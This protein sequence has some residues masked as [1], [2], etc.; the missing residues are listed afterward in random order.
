MKVACIGWGSLVW[1]PGEIRCAGPWQ[2]DGPLLPLEFARTSRDGRL[3]LVLTEAADPRPTQWVRVLYTAPDDAREALAK[4]EG[5]ALSAIG[6]W[7]GP[8]P[9]HSIGAIVVA[10]WAAT[11]GLDAVVWTALRPKFNG[12]SGAVPGSAEAAIAYLT[13][14]DAKAA[15]LARE[16]VVQAPRTVRTR[17]RTAFEEQLGW[18]PASRTSANALLG[19]AGVADEGFHAL[20][21][22]QPT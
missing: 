4:R 1:K 9:R 13:S 11:I 15:A 14:L 5:C 8:A 10:E 21:G 6:L 12:V 7:P 19:H 16:Y 22:A 2:P 20:C 18:R 17:L 3:T